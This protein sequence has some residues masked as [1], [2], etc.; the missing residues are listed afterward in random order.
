MILVREWDAAEYERLSAPQTRWGARVLGLI[1]LRG[2]EA[3]IDEL[4]IHSEERLRALTRK[5]LRDYPGVRHFEE[6]DDVFQ[7]STL[8]LLRS[9]KSVEL[10]DDVHFFRHAVGLFGRLSQLLALFDRLFDRYRR[11]RD[12]SPA[13]RPR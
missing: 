5:L 1:D 9:L 2:D 7:A 13:C 3:A 4:F 6:T 12:G 10:I 8:R 11:A